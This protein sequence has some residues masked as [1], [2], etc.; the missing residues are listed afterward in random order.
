MANEWAG[1]PTTFGAP[2]PD[3]FADEAAMF[4][5][6]NGTIR[7]T[8]AVAAAAEPAAPTTMVMAN[9]GRLIMP[10]QSAQRLSLAL[11]DF[12]K[13]RDLDPAALVSGDQ[14]AN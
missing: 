3:V 5:I 13:Q 4:D 2:V 10:I 11:Y 8:F 7:I 12:L 9:V 1:M 14:Q 6:I